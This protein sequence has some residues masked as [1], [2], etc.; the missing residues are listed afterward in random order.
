[1]SDKEQNAEALQDEDKE[2]SLDDEI[3]GMFDE[4]DAKEAPADKKPKPQKSKVDPMTV[5]KN[6]TVD[7]AL[8]VDS[9]P[10]LLSDLVEMAEGDVLPMSRKVDEPLDVCVN[11]QL[12]AKG[13]IVIVDGRYGFRITEV[14]NSVGGNIG[15]S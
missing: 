7:L 11:G 5:F 8:Q 3:E 2:V 13:E 9:V 14:V 6:V 15:E 10:V 1:M 12:V 4:E